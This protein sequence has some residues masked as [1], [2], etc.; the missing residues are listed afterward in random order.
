MTPSPFAPARF[1]DLPAIAGI[2]MGTA[3][4]GI[5]YKN[6]DDLW[7][8]RGQAGTQMAAV[9]TRNRM[10][11][12]PVIWSRRALMAP[13]NPKAPRILVVNSGNSN[14]FTGD[15]GKKATALTAEV[16]EKVFA[17]EAE[18]VMLAS[19]G[20]IGEVLDV[21]KI[22]RAMPDVRTHMTPD[23]WEAAA[24]AIMTTD[25]YP[26]GASAEAKIGDVTVRINGI[27]KGSGMIAPDMATM[28]AFIATDANISQSVLQSMLSGFTQLTF[29][30]ITVDSDTST[31]DMV[32]LAASGAAD[33]LPMSDPHD[34]ALGDFKNALLKVMLSLSHQVIKDGEGAKKFIAV[35][36]T[37]AVN[38]DSA[39]KVAMSIANSPLVKTAIAGEDANWGRIV[40]AVGK[41]GE[42]ADPEKLTVALGPN[43]ISRNG[44]LAPEYSEDRGAKYM[45]RDHLEINVDLGLGHGTYTAWTCDLTHDYIDINAEYRS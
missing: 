15:V 39:R 12:A 24:R 16:A 7:I 42:P 8:L 34:P 20:V 37:G 10:P 40:M 22:V 28:L 26:K 23:G 30:A 29:N 33:H 1:P 36:V 18:T 11:G 43:V 2:D 19:T 25:T 32:L 44:Q 31:S 21:G 6:R 13:D 35:N 45:K 17:A 4:C 5:K 3:A 14:V 9:F 41:S 27:A 38:D